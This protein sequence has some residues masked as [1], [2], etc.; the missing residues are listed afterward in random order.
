MRAIPLAH[1]LATRGG[2]DVEVELK[3]AA[4]RMTEALRDLGSADMVHAV[5]HRL[6]GYRARHGRRVAWRRLTRSQGNS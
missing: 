1:G 5:V 3:D 4:Q 2:A 6:P